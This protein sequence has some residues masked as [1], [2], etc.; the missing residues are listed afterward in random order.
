MGNYFLDNDRYGIQSRTYYKTGTCTGGIPQPIDE[1]G[2]DL[3]AVKELLCDSDCNVIFS[4]GRA[5]IEQMNMLD[6]TIL[7]KH[8]VNIYNIKDADQLKNT[9]RWLKDDYFPNK[10]AGEMDDVENIKLLKGMMRESEAD[11][12][13]SLKNV[14]LQH[15]THLR[16][17]FYS[18][19][20]F[21]KTPRFEA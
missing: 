6:T 11:R 14:Q 9:I 19:K 2:T 4:D 10:Q 13:W 21:R 1:N 16:S 15:I 8:L 3:F 17:K 12:L 5:T 7:L 18:G 20:E